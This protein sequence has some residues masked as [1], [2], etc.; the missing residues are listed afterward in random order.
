MK[1][2]IMV[3]M[4]SVTIGI[5]SAHAE[6]INV[7]FD[8]G[9]VPQNTGIKELIEPVTT[10]IQPQFAEVVSIKG[11]TKI[12]SPQHYE[13]KTP[14]RETANEILQKAT[15]GFEAAGY[16]IIN[17]NIS[18]EYV[19]EAGEKYPIWT[20]Y[21]DYLSPSG[22]AHRRYE[23]KFNTNAESAASLPN[24]VKKFEA[25]GYVV[26]YAITGSYYSESAGL[27]YYVGLDY[28]P[29]VKFPQRFAE[30]ENAQ[31]GTQN[32]PQAKGTPQVNCWEDNCRMENGCGNIKSCNRNCQLLGGACGV[33]G[34]WITL[35]YTGGTQPTLAHGI[36]TFVGIGCD[37]ACKEWACEDI[38]DCKPV[39]KCDTHCVV[40]TSTN[41][42]SVDMNTGQVI[43]Q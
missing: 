29:L 20:A 12:A 28:I 18:V 11:A 8:G 40:T 41:G 33:A 36:G 21:V 35:Y 31:F 10:N 15:K 34:R 26:I 17:S 3:W 43:Y 42:D 24:I 7:S 39:K 14:M 23:A 38:A 22:E 25:A 30:F 19:T 1:K 5:V 32:M 6:G 27:E 9:D 16:V 4:L 2:S 13:R 37:L